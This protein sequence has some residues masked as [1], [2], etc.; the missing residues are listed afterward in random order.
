MA[1]ISCDEC[2][3]E[4]SDQANSC[5]KCGF[6]LTKETHKN[7][8]PNMIRLKS[9]EL[10]TVVIACIILLILWN[11]SQIAEKTN[12]EAYEE[13]QECQEQNPSITISPECSDERDDWLDAMDEDISAYE[14]FFNTM[15]IFGIILSIYS[16]RK[17]IKST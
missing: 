8:I 3:A 4:I 7:A 14:T 12:D 2:G 10:I 15:I 16:I 17:Y 1:L 13:Y 11:S 6:P 9:N 5:P